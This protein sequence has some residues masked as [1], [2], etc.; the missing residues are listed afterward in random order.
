MNEKNLKTYI[1]K[2]FDELTLSE[3]IAGHNYKGVLK[4]NIDL[5]FEKESVYHAYNI[6]EIFL[7]IYQITDESDTKNIKYMNDA[8]I[9][10]DCVKIM[11]KY[12]RMSKERPYDSLIH[13]VKVF[14]LGL[15]IYTQN[16]NYREI[17]EEKIKNSPYQEYYQ[18]KNEI[19]S[20]EFL[21]RW[22]ITSFFQNIGINIEI[23][24]KSLQKLL[25]EEI[26]A[27]IYSKGD[28]INIDLLNF[29]KLDLSIQN[30]TFRNK[31]NEKYPEAQFLE[32]KYSDM[33]VHKLYLNFNLNKRQQ[34]YLKNNLEQLLINCP[35]DK[36][37]S[38]E[39]SVISAIIILNIYEYLVQ[40]YER[41]P[42][43]FY[44]PILDSATAILLKNFYKDTLIREPFKLKQLTPS[45]NPLAF[46][47][48][49]CHNLMKPAKPADVDKQQHTTEPSY[50][51]D[52]NKL[53]LKYV[54]KKST[55][56]VNPDD[57]KQQLTYVLDLPSIFGKGVTLKTEV[58]TD[59]Y[60]IR[61]KK[62]SDLDSPNLPIYLVYKLAKEIHNFYHEYDENYSFDNLSSDI[63]YYNVKHMD[64]SIKR[65]RK[66]GY[67]IVTIDDEGKAITS[68]KEEFIEYL[69]KEEH[70]EWMNDKQ[71]MGWIYGE[72]KDEKDKTNPYMV[73]WEKLSP[74]KQE[75]NRITCRNYP[76]ICDNVG[77]KII[78]E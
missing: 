22:G 49:L 61:E 14:L 40:K 64:S 21:Y 34:N 2:F 13:S 46:L 10:L 11:F 42:D 72:I 69:S 62:R 28:N 12:E 66:C 15:A 74:K 68:F 47:L 56:I 25:N 57:I 76:I 27:V 41:N 6:Y 7:S 45:Q 55:M 39:Y 44:Y 8:N 33:L 1:D 23:I 73:N 63:K 53:N 50:Y 60:S 32:F 9:P 52:D 67:K 58:K 77:L 4:A 36:D 20:E 35:S 26:N 24:G 54:V 16:R 48:I 19:S 51:I 70:Y 37:S 31:Y 71:D 38:T 5:F 29:Q 75:E 78:L 43:L 30:K 17:F 59:L 65:L 3:D 18:I